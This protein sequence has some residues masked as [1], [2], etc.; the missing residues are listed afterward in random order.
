MLRTGDGTIGP[1]HGRVSR[2]V[3]GLRALLHMTI[4]NTECCNSA[5]QH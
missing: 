3:Y 1:C 5:C 4:R 2:E